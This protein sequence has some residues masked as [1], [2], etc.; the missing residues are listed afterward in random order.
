MCE[1]PLVYPATILFLCGLSRT[2]RRWTGLCTIEWVLNIACR[3]HAQVVMCSSLIGGDIASDV[4]M[5]LE[6]SQ[7]RRNEPHTSTLLYDRVVHSPMLSIIR[8]INAEMY[9]QSLILHCPHGYGTP[10]WT[11]RAHRGESSTT[12]FREWFHRATMSTFCPARHSILCRHPAPRGPQFAVSSK[13]FVGVTL[14]NGRLNW[15]V[16]PRRAVRY[17]TIEGGGYQPVFIHNF[18]RYVS[19]DRRCG[20]N[21]SAKLDRMLKR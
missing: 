18:H 20:I 3:C 2:N 17:V 19:I 8:A 1:L 11:K 13:R 9:P 4:W 12:R 10:S 6:Q 14:S 5:K 15:A 21:R 7:S 16:N